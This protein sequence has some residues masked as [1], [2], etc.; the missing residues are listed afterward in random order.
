M[1]FPAITRAYGLQPAN[2]IGG[3]VFAG[4]TR[5]VPIASTAANMFNGDIVQLN[6]TGSLT[7]STLTSAVSISGGVPSAQAIVPGTIGVFAG[8]EYSTTGGPLFGKMRNQYW[9]T[10][11]STAQDAVGYVVD[12]PDTV[13]KSAVLAQ[14]QSTTTSANTSTTIGY[15]SPAFVGS[16]VYYVGGNG[17]STATGNS[18]GGVSGFAPQTAGSAAGNLRLPSHASNQG[19][20]RVVGL[21]PETAVSIVTTASAGSTTTAINVPSATGIQPGM[22]I[23]VAGATGVGSPSSNAVVTAVVG[24]A[25]SVTTLGAAPT[26]GTVITFVGYP[27]VLVKLNQGYHS[28]YNAQS[29]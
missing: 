13:F 18:L 26:A 21:V 19:A 24:N 2:L 3:Q 15:M 16:N 6:S 10:A 4:S 27:E 20:F 7:I 9:S 29:A 8:V 25:V 14:S 17:G 28:Y 22:Q 1:A 12:D 23:I 5:M 11:F